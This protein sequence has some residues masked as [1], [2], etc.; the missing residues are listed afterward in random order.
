M[1]QHRHHHVEPNV[2]SVRTLIV[3]KNFAIQK[4]IS[5]IGLGVSARN[6][7]AVLRR[8]G[9]WTDVISAQTSDELKKQLES[10]IETARQNR[11]VPLSHVNISAPW[12]PTNDLAQLVMRYPT[13]VFTIT[14]HSNVGFLQA[15]A[16]GTKLLRE[17]YDLSH[18][19]DNIRVAGNCRRYTEWVE[20]SFNTRCYYLPNLYDLSTIT[21]KSKPQWHSGTLRVGCFGATRPYKN[22]ITA[23]AAA[24]E[25]S[26]LLNTD[27]EFWYSG[28]RAEGGGVIIEAA[29]AML[30]NLPRVK[31]VE[32]LW[33][34]WP[35]FRRVVG[36][37]SI[38]M[39]PSFTESFNMV[40]ADGIAEGVPSVVS[41]AI[42]WVP[43]HWITPSDNADAIAKKAVQLLYDHHAPHDG[44]RALTDYVDSGIK[45]WTAFFLEPERFTGII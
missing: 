45:D 34:P 27:V 3:Y 33:V 20:R 32:Q 40:T 10:I 35:A 11:Q 18:G 6:T 42:D 39:Q 24:V 14:S 37:M 15:D 22:L 30:G 17:S 7:G 19:F 29:K 23:A 43:H 36:S 25:L 12:V 16:N 28:G 5:H 38:L 26:K 9:F 4:G 2:K 8:A 21:P 31:I 44:L 41:D 1:A 13:I